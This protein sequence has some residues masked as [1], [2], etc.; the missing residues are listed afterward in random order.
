MVDPAKAALRAELRAR[1]DN[2]VLDL[3]AQAR[4]A[5]E[6]QAADL[7]WPL[8]ADA[9]AVSFYMAEGSEMSCAALIAQARAAGIA[10]LLPY[11]AALRV[12]L[13]FLRWEADVALE[14]GWRGLRQPPADS[15]ESAPDI[16]V[17]P[18]LGYDSDRWRLGQGAGFYDRA[19]A[20]HPHARRIGIAW[21]VQHC[22]HV[23][24]DPWDERLDAI[25]TE[26]GLIEGTTR[27]A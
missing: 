1:R 20:D 5:Q 23:P 18:L 21:A 22:D 26:R 19:F 9:R 15:A 2:H 25:V 10:I 11:V 17:T 27:D 13:R 14:S 3:G 16:I 7:L 4:D 24:R 8:I 12:P 6:R